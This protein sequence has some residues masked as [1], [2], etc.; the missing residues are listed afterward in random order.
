MYNRAVDFWLLL[1][2]LLQQLQEI[3]ALGPSIKAS[4]VFTQL[5]GAHQRF[6]RQMLMAAKV[7]DNPSPITSCLEP[8]TATAWIPDIEPALNQATRLLPVRS[9]TFHPRSP[10]Q[11][12][13]GLPESPYRMSAIGLTH[14]L[15]YPRE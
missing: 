6:F 5:W 11:V 2:Q 9:I 8:C 14:S 4:R 13:S 12:P 3:G 15:F 10:Y 7:G 1:I